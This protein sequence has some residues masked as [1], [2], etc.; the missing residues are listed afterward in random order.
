M[1]DDNKS[2][3]DSE[4]TVSQALPERVKNNENLDIG[5]NSY[6]SNPEDEEVG[7]LIDKILTILGLK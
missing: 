6:L 7:D 5:A 1:S 4:S 3:A 2:Q